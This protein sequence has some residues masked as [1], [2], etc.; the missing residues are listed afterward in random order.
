MKI[1]KNLSDAEM[2]K[3]FKEKESFET[4]ILKDSSVEKKVPVKKES[5]PIISLPEDV[6]VKLDKAVLHLLFSLKQKGH[7]QIKW[8]LT[9]KN[10]EIILKPIAKAAK[11]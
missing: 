2:L 3:N 1:K 11:P 4:A 6:V 8:Q 9:A 7:T 5:V 10:D